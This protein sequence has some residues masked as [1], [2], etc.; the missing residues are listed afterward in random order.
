MFFLKKLILTN[1][2]GTYLYQEVKIYS[3]CSYKNNVLIV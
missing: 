1:Y 3:M 2:T